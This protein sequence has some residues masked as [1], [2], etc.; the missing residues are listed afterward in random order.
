MRVR[1]KRTSLPVL[2]QLLLGADEL[3]VGQ[4]CRAQWQALQLIQGRQSE[5]L[6][7]GIAKTI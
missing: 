3:E 7:Q 2:K 4:S 6:Q 1:V 5:E